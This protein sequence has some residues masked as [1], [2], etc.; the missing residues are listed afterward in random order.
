M[1]ALKA[2]EEGDFET[3]KKKN[4]RSLYCSIASIVTGVIH[5]VLVTAAGTCALLYLILFFLVIAA[6]KASPRPPMDSDEMNIILEFHFKWT[7][8]L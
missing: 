3:Y 6:F 5:I 4:R 2:A 8:V 7:G 1:Q